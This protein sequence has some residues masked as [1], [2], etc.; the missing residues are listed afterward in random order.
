VALDLALELHRRG[1]QVSIACLHEPGALAA[2][3]EAAGIRVQAFHKSQGFSPRV[4]WAA[5]RHFRAERPEV[6]HTHNPGVH[7][8]AAV[9]ARAARA[10]CVLCTRHGPLSSTGEPYN[11]RWFRAVTPWTDH[12]VH[13]SQHTLRI[14]VG[15]RGLSA[16]KSRVLYNGIRLDRFVACAAQPAAHWPVLR[17]GTLGRLVP[18]KG[19]SVLLKSFARAISSLPAATLTIAGGGALEQDLRREA[20]SLGLEDKVFFPGTT[21]DTPG[22]LASL[23]LFVFPSLSEGLPLAIL[24]AM[25][26]GLPIIATRVGG[27]PEVAPE[28]ELAWYA[29]PGDVE[30]LAALM[31]S[32]ATDRAELIRRGAAA[33]ARAFERYSVEFMT[34]QYEALYRETPHT[35]QWRT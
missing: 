5:V 2:E 3:A 28:G 6:V 26:A 35:R 23:D 1:H 4:L 12:V 9:A 30:E 14:L 25:A 27:V 17:L 32:A 22:F 16:A 20:R 10:R 31:V 11:E 29:N 7:H 24:E 18:M 19:H 8:Y 21:A 15:E 33:R 34:D 13:V